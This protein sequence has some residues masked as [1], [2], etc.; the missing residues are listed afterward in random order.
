M[1]P[2]MESRSHDSQ[3][4]YCS[5][6]D[7][8]L[9]SMS[10]PHLTHHTIYVLEKDITSD[11]RCQHNNICIVARR[12]WQCADCIEKQLKGHCIEFGMV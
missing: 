6:C 1:T 8:W 5:N 9:A 12:P 3:F 7:N 4:E 2:P 10:N 11:D